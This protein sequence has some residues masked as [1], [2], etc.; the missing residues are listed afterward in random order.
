MLAETI[1]VIAF[2]RI[3]PFLLAMPCT[4]FREDRR[5]PEMP[6]F[7]LLVCSC[8]TKE[9]NSE[10]GFTLRT[11]HLLEGLERADLVIVPSWRDPDELPPERLLLA[12]RR[13]HD[14]GAIIVGLCLGT[15]VLAA[16]GLLDNRTATTHWGWADD[17]ARRYPLISV[18]PD[19]LYVDE[20]DVITSAGVA[21]GI[22]CCLHILRKRHG[23][24]VAAKVARRMVV[25]PH[26]QGGQAQYI[27]QPLPPAGLPERFAQLL[28]WL[29][30]H[31]D[32]PHSLDSLAARLG[33][34]R[35]T[36]TRH[37]N[38]HTGTTVGAWLLNQRL[39]LAQQ[40]LEQS[41][42]PLVLIAERAG[43]GSE[44]SLRQQ[45]GKVLRTTPSRYRREFRLPI[46]RQAERKSELVE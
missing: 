13:A 19:V 44:V 25:P 28:D 45:F 14:R 20:G 31:L 38:R 29:Q 37:F 5:H 23:A 27:E 24:E 11:N 42:L 2:D 36:F 3:S 16:A 9:L 6:R 12:L 34:S 39:A 22:D 32:R 1:A 43:F 21:A 7:N 30:G 40:L 26:R 8:E 15:F 41:D 4:V 35:R 17:L 46:A 18:K 33:M 10:A